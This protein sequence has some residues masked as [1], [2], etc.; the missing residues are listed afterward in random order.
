MAW[1][2]SSVALVCSQF[3]H[4]L[5]PISIVLLSLWD[6]SSIRRADVYSGSGEGYCPVI[7]D[8]PFTSGLERKPCCVSVH[9][10]C[11]QRVVLVFISSVDKV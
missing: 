9:F 1:L 7:F 8:G 6:G 3:G 2:C 10:K 5:K 11:R 4:L